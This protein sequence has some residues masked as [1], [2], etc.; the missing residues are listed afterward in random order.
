MMGKG[1]P[2]QVLMK[3]VGGGRKFGLQLF[4]A[5]STQVA[6]LALSCGRNKYSFL[7]NFP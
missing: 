2:K 7:F 4:N 6:F 5:R 1:G 3:G